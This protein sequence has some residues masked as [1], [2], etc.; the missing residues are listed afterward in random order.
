MLP[1]SVL[2]CLYYKERPD[3]LSQ[4][5]DSVFNQTVLPNEVVLVED[6]PLTDELYA[7]VEAYRSKYPQLRV[8]KLPCNGGLGKALNVGLQH[9]SYDLVA[10]MDTDDI[11]YPDRFEKQLN[12]FRSDPKVDLCGAWIAEF[13]GEPSHVVSVRKVPEKHGEIY[14]Y[15]KQRSPVNHPVVMFRKSAVLKAGGYLHF[16]L[17]E[18][19]YLWAR[20]LMNGACFYNL[21]ESLLYFRFSPDMFRRRG[22]WRYAMTELRLQWL[23]Y[24]ISFIGIP[25]MLKNCA[26]R[27]AARLM[28]N[29][30]RSTLY[31][32]LIRSC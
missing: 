17:F 8:V 31:K 19:Y 10:R 16:P 6:G 30:L 9:C 13:E 12:V 28:P 20:M 5:L 24:R 21:P 14:R 18:D 26:I 29:Q 11:A 27:L 23:F 32:R 1:F 25:L 4:S 3:F 2:L 22:G 7:V 15:A